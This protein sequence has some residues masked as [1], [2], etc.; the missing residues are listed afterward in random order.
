VVTSGSS[1]TTVPGRRNILGSGALRQARGLGQPCPGRRAAAFA[2]LFGVV[3]ACTVAGVGPF[4]L[5]SG[6]VAGFLVA[7]G[8]VAVPVVAAFASVGRR[9][10]SSR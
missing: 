5:C 8:L 3:L 2:G 9:A 7:V 1:G 10:T 6:S 4:D